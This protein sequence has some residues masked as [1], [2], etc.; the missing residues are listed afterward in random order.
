MRD[1]RAGGSAAAATSG[2]GLRTFLAVDAGG[3]TWAVEA[4]AVRRVLQDA[5]WSGEAVDV[6]R[7]FGLEI[8]PK[9]GL[10]HVLV[11][12]KGAVEVAV[13]AHGHI[14]LIDV[15]RKDVHPVP[16][17]ILGI[18]RSLVSEVA[19]RKSSAPAAE[20]PPLLIVDVAALERMAPE[21]SEGSET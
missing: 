10:G 21:N 12:G 3:S 1:I 13:R 14:S 2:E 4:G 19:F 20:L 17:D 6:A 5:E 8:E 9:D 18:T 11:V 7:T 16:A 15:A